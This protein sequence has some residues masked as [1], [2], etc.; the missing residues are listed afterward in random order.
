MIAELYRTGTASGLEVGAT[1]PDFTLTDARGEAVSLS[2]RLADGPVVLVFYRGSWCPLCQVHLRE[3]QAQLDRIR[4]R[5]AALLAVSPQGPER[6]GPFADDLD[7]DFDVLSDLDQQVAT[8]YGVRFRLSD[9]VIELYTGLG[10]VLPDQ[11]ADGSWHLPVPATFVIAPDATVV[12]RHVEAD[13]SQR[14]T[15]DAIVA[16]LDGI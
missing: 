12:A 11:N 4:E 9:D 13:Y 15:V 14:M 2:D 1:A 10:L 3:V 5:G 6:S 7:L 8:D 16:A